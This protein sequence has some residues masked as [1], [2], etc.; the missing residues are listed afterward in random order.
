[1]RKKVAFSVI[2]YGSMGF[3]NRVKL[4]VGKL[5]ARVHVC[6]S[7]PGKLS[8]VTRTFAVIQTSSR[9]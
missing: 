5:K 9:V 8:V 3:R 1:M 7:A 4:C 2:F 6:V